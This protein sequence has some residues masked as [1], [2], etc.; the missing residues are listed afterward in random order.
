MQIVG[1]A[2]GADRSVVRGD[3]AKA[4]FSVF[5]YAGDQLVAVESINSPTDHMTGRKLIANGSNIAPDQAEDP[6]YDLK[7]ALLKNTNE[8]NSR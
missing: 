4:R 1:A 7:T 2:V 3:P 8:S 6:H 5:R